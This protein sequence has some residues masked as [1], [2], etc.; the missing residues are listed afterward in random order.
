MELDDDGNAPLSL[1]TNKRQQSL[2]PASEAQNVD[3][4]AEQQ[5]S[6]LHSKVKR[7]K[8]A[9]LDPERIVCLDEAKGAC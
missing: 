2:E 6:G 3:L 7:R 9:P 5:S 4:E 1:F 8:G